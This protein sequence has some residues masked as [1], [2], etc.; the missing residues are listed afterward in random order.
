MTGFGAKFYMGNL[1]V[2]G[3]YVETDFETYHHTSTTGDKNSI[4]ADI[5]TEETRFSLGY[6]F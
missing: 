3:E 2:K 6:N 4:D 1:F 5:S